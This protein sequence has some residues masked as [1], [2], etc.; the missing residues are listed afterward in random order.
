MFVVKRRHGW[1]NR[2]MCSSILCFFSSNFLAKACS[3]K[4]GRWRFVK[5]DEIWISFSIC[6]YDSSRVLCFITLT[7]VFSHPN[8]P[9]SARKHVSYIMWGI[10]SQ[11]CWKNRASMFC[12]FLWCFMIYA[13]IKWIFF[14]FFW[15]F[16][17]SLVVFCPKTASSS[18]NIKAHHSN[19]LRSAPLTWALNTHRISIPSA[20]YFA[21]QISRPAFMTHRISSEGVFFYKE[22]GVYDALCSSRE[23]HNCT[24]LA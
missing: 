11:L 8:P 18:L 13:C 22:L 6:F 19:A 17:A 23:W 4:G 3:N 20:K 12:V 16:N 9:L 7:I 14:L 21:V 15:C 2:N 5:C 10:F 24:I 1:G